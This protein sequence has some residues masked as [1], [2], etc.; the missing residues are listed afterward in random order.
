MSPGVYQAYL[1]ASN[2]YSGWIS[3]QP[4]TI[5]VNSLPM[6]SY[7]ASPTS[8]APNTSVK[9]NDQSTGF[10]SPTSWYWD[11]GD[12]YNSTQQNPVHQYVQAGSDT[13]LH[14]A[15]SAQGTGWLNKTAYISIS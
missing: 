2:E 1:K 12:G 15:T 10:P 7:T 5:T 3:A 8:G 4:Q 14:S 11:F 13:V 6:V 9:F